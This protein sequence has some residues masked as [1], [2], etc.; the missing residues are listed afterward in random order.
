MS[1]EV[2]DAL[3][4]V[5]VGDTSRGPTPNDHYCWT[6][7][8]DIDYPRPVYECHSCSDLGA[9]MAAA[10]AA[11]SIVFKDNKA[12]SQKL[13]HGAKPSLSFLGIS[14]ADTVQVVQMLRYSIIP[15]VIGT[16]TSGVQLG[17]IMPLVTHPIFNLILLLILPNM[18]VPSGE[19]LIMAC[20]AGTTSLLEPKPQPLQY[21]VDAAFLA[22]LYSDYLAA[23]DTPGSYCGPNFYSTDVIRKFAETQISGVLEKMPDSA[24]KL[25]KERLTDTNE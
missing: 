13:V 24:D 10:L 5:G 19:V 6:R 4:K 25:E 2:V 3:N 7:P 12:Y 14:V 15:P 16:N 9:E 20:L 11:A 22:T 21:V 18:L 1:S 17:Y 23:A 8:E